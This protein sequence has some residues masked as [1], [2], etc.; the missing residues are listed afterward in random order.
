MQSQMAGNIAGT[1]IMSYDRG[2]SDTHVMPHDRE[3]YLVL[4]YWHMTKN[5]SGIYAVI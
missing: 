3:K 1:H 2:K 4:M 5:M